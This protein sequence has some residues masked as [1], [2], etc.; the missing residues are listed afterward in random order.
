MTANDGLRSS[1]FLLNVFSRK[2]YVMS[3]DRLIVAIGNI[4]RALS[5]LEKIEFHKPNLQNDDAELRA[6][7]EA[8]K[9][10]TRAAIHEIDALIGKEAQ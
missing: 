6:R 5:R 10:E 9:A 1:R 2:V 3:Q 4:E 8:L 7:H